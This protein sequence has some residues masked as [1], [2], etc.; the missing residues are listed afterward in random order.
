M[1]VDHEQMAALAAELD[2][3]L[4]CAA[5]PDGAEAATIGTIPAIIAKGRELVGLLR[6]GKALESLNAL[7]DLLGLLLGRGDGGD[8]SISFAPQAAA[9]GLKFD[10]FKSILKRLLPLLLEAL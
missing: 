10:L 8:G 5:V 4:T 1:S 7:Y 9:A 2:E 6:A 3:C